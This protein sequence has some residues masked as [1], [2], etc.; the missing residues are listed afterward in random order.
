MVALISFCGSINLYIAVGMSR[1]QTPSLFC[2]L[3]CMPY[4]S[5]VIRHFSFN[6]DT[7]SLVIKE[8]SLVLPNHFVF[9]L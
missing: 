4:V 5:L 1:E 3:L 9:E 8:L 6:D 2:K 7:A